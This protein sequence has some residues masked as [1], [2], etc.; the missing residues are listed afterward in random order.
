MTRKDKAGKVPPPDA[1]VGLGFGGLL[2][3]IQKLVDAAAK[4]KDAGG[5][6]QTGEFSIPGLGEKG[7]GLFGFSIRTMA[8]GQGSGVKVQPFGDIHKTQE[9][10]TVEEDRE[11]V[12]DVVEEGEQIRVITELPGVSEGEIAH[13][14]HGDVLVIS[15]RGERRYHAEVVLPARVQSEG[16]ASS[17]NNGILELRLHKAKVE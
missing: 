8:D 7:K 6:S 12:V 14:V 2:E 13:E 17:Y 3:G 10:M 4:L 11:P 9:G 16:A 15:T 1:A 5:V